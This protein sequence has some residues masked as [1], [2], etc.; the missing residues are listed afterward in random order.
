[1]SKFEGHYDLWTKNRVDFIVNRFGNNFFSD[2]SILDIGGGKGH[3]LELLPKNIKSAEIVEG[4]YTNFNDKFTYS[5]NNLEYEL[6]T[7]HKKY[8]IVFNFGVLYHITNWELFLVNSILKAKDIV[9]FETEV[10]DYET[11]MTFYSLENSTFYDQAISG[12]GSRPTE[13]A[14]ENLLK[15]IPFITFEKIKDGSLNAEFHRYDWQ[16]TYQFRIEN[17]LRR[18]YIIRITPQSI[19]QKIRNYFLIKELKEFLYK[20][21]VLE[22]LTYTH[23]HEK[24]TEDKLHQIIMRL[25]FMEKNR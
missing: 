22:L 24:I 17:G 14:I 1:M 21:K 4:R 7:K 18:F 8:N 2:K 19:F 10:L 9:F 13:F 5:M 3:L 12:L 15:K 16:N 20:Q 6:S 25:E 11:D 23:K